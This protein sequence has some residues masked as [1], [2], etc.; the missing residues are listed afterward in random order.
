MKVAQ[1]LKE[2][3]IARQVGFAE[4][5]KHPQVRLEQGEQT[6]RPILMHVTP[7]V[8]FLG[9]VDELVHVALQRPIAAGRVGIEP[10]A[11][12][13][14]HVGCF[15][16]CLYCE[17][18]RRMDHN[19]PLTADPRDD[20]R[21]VFVIM[22]PARLTLLTATTRSATQMLCTALLGLSL[23]ARGVVEV[24][25]LNCALP[26]TI[27]RLG[28]ARI[29]QPPAPAIGRTAMHPQLSR[30][31]ARRTREAQQEGGQNPVCARPPAL[32]EQGMGEVVEGPL[33]AV[34]P[35]A[36]TP[37]AVVVRPPG[38]D[39]LALA[40]RTRKRAFFPPERVDVGLTV[41]GVEELVDI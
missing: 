5:S 30:N 36:L 28:D 32:V 39:V 4:A 23:L 7:G 11:C 31:T 3:H 12:L 25:R 27:S 9:V 16:Y 14:G 19:G 41:F 20:G 29:P 37:R 38:I 22:A 15:L 40:P 1:E 10:T 13:H 35:V 24:I 17:I 21:P 34:A 6:L 18:F 2:A 33:A 8:L 26:L